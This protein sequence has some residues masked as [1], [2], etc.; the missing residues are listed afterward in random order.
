LGLP[1]A[2]RPVHASERQNADKIFL[3][4]TAGGIVPISHLDGRIFGNDRPGPI[5]SHLRETFRAE[6]ADDWH[7]TPIEHD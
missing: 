5:P 2:I 7:P 4:T 3:L 6:W 1:F